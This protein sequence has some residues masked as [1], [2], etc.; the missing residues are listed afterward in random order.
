M[1]EGAHL[2]A[3]TDRMGRFSGYYKCSVC[4]AEFRPNPKFPQEILISF[5]AHVR[6]LH[7]GSET[8]RQGPKSASP[9]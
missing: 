1:R 2:T 4:K 6:Y 5:A 9:Q 7:P 3:A 8:T